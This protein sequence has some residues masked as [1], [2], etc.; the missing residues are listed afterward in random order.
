MKGVTQEEVSKLTKAMKDQ[1][2][3]DH[4][5]EYVKDSTS[6]LALQQTNAPSSFSSRTLN[7]S[8]SLLLFQLQAYKCKQ[9]MHIYPYM[10]SLELDSL[11]AVDSL[12][13]FS[14][15]DHNKQHR[16]L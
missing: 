12:W 11:L 5:D 3:R 7:R 8:L 14:R 4:M 2:F 9:F 16:T 6:G 15:S 1:Q 13:G 10:I